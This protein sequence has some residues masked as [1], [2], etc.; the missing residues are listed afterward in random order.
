MTDALENSILARVIAAIQ[1]TA[2]SQ[3]LAIN[4]ESRFVEDLDLDSLDVTEVVLHI[5]EAFDTEFS[6]ETIAR[7]H[8]VSDVVNHLSRRFFPDAA[9]FTRARMA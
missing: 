6:S 1:E 3:T 5:E 4:R 2:F 7:F 9:E 8:S